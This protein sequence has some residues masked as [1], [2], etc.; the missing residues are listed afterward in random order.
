[1]K[2]NHAVNSQEAAFGWNGELSQV[3]RRK[4]VEERV[5]ARSLS[6]IFRHNET[7]KIV[8]DV[9]KIIVVDL[10]RKKCDCGE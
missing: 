2:E 7:F 3:M 9:K 10:L 1:M 6:V 8:E 5:E 4:I